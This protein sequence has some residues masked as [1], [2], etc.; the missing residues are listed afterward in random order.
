ME[1]QLLAAV[2]PWR[3]FPRWRRFR[4]C[5]LGENIAAPLQDARGVQLLELVIA[6]VI[7]GIA[8]GLAMPYITSRPAHLRAD[9]NELIANLKVAREWSVA[10]MRHY[11]VRVTDSTTYVIEEGEWQGGGWSFGN[12]RTLKLSPGVRFTGAGGAQ[13]EFNTRGQLVGNEVSFVLRDDRGQ[14]RRVVVRRTG[15][16]GEQ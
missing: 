2:Q 8:L 15:M 12:A 7:L 1:E 14:E 9:T 10:R 11:R 5:G 4:N 3:V 13:A 6:L 16:V